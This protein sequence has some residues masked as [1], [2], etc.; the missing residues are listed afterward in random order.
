[1]NIADVP[2]RGCMDTPTK[3]LQ[4]YVDD[5]CH[6]AAQSVD[7]AHI[8][9][10][11]WAAV[12]GIHALFPPPSITNHM[13][14][15]EPILQKK[16]AQGNGNF[17]TKKEMIGF[18]FDGATRTV[19][20]PA[21]KA[22]AYIKEAHKVLRRKTVQLKSMQALVGKLRHASIILPAAKGFFTPINTA[23]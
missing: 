22:K 6:A 8:P 15:K 18:L 12:H 11:R 23:L 21:K 13:G 4:V 14:S 2:I 5:F 9:T 19:R 20:L 3:L 1:M 10:I 7:D 16:M 17:D